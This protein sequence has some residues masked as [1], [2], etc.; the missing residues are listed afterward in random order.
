MRALIAI[1]CT[2]V[3][4]SCGGNMLSCRGDEPPPMAEVE[5]VIDSFEPG[6]IVPPWIG[7]T[8]LEERI[9]NSNLIVRV[10]FRSATTT[11]VTVYERETHPTLVFRPTGK[12]VPGLKLTFDALI[13]ASSP[14]GTG[15]PWNWRPTIAAT[16]RSRMPSETSSTASASTISPRAASP[17]TAPGWP[18]RCWPITWPAG[19]RASVWA[20]G[21]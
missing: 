12:Y 10:R 1:V 4:L 19:P 2:I 15:K 18:S 5:E 6:L 14:T 7:P 16:P 13:T 9:L 17:P 3:M 21:W 8:T 20:R 11:G